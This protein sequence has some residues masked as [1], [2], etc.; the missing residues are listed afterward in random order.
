MHDFAWWSG[1][2]MKDVKEGI[3][4]HTLILKKEK[5]DK[6]EYF[7]L[8][9]K[10]NMKHDAQTSFLMPD[11]DEYGISYKDRSILFAQHHNRQRE[12]SN[13]I[14]NHMII[15]DGMIAGTWQR[16]I[17]NNK[18]KITTKIYDK[19]TV[20]IQNEIKAAKKRYLYFMT[21]EKSE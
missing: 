9:Q 13:P 11:Y 8:P 14:F 2:S 18:I 16:S 7:Y 10:S 21:G 12:K 1:L 17:N 4:M 20:S 3:G 19:P 5:I 6:Q 15:L